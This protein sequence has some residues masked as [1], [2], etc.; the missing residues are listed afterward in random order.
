M[1]SESLGFAVFELVELV[2]RVFKDF[3]KKL[4]SIQ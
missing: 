2:S 3:K 4:S 1:K